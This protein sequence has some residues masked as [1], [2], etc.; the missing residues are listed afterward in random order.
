MDMDLE[1]QIRIWNSLE[2]Y[3]S[4]IEAIG[5]LDADEIT[6]EL[7][8][9]AGKAY[10]NL[11][12]GEDRDLLKMG[13][14][15]LSS[16]ED[17]LSDDHH[18]NFRM[19]FAN[20]WLDREGDA[21][22]Y[23]RKA[24][25]LM[26][27]D[28]Q[29]QQLLDDCLDR[30]ALPEFDQTFR[31]RVQSAWREFLDEESS[32]RSMIQAEIAGTETEDPEDDEADSVA[33]K[34]DGILSH[35]LYNSSFELGFDGKSYELTLT[36]DA[37][38]AEVFKLRYFKEHAPKEVFE[39]WKVNLG[40]QVDPSFTIEINGEELTAKDIRV[41]TEWDDDGVS[42]SLYGKQVVP[43]LHDDPDQAGW[44]FSAL[45]DH[46]LGEICAMDLVNELTLLDEPQDE[47]G[48]PLS[49]LPTALFKAGYSLS[50]D[51]ERMTDIPTE[52]ECEPIEDEEAD[53][54]LD[55][56]KGVITCPALLSEYYE[57][58]DDVMNSFHDDGAV[59][60][61]ICWPIEAVE[62]NNR[63][64]AL[65]SFSDKL[66]EGILKRAGS[67]SVTFIG[68]ATGLY[69]GYLDF[70]AWDLPEVLEAAETTLNELHMPEGAFHT[71]RREGETF[72]VVDDDEGTGETGQQA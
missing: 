58:E 20:Y 57:G 63:V 65:R 66:E 42:L 61:F 72:S 47:G 3:E 37:G 7:I 45:L 17:E 54:R 43:L 22:P 49:N 36:S 9:E 23:F 46:T 51:I 6:P 10:C 2:D 31:D 5:Q 50:N 18:W 40:R 59:P 32:I 39:H 15:L 25:E 41:W 12:N 24:L 1:N 28:Q 48:M 70:I 14:D 64:D 16:V 34:M 35:A 67:S 68:H 55:V 8:S 29:S 27:D 30:I 26:P 21:V 33:E 11:A 44:V 19:G 71:F 62:G 4:I 13:L 60:G 69:A 56:T 52:Y 38:P 53:W